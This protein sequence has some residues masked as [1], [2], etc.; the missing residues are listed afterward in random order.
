M[1]SF[2][3]RMATQKYITPQ[4]LIIMGT[5]GPNPISEFGLI[6]CKIIRK[7]NGSHHVSPLVESMAFGSY[8]N[9]F[10]DENDNRSW[11]T[12][13]VDI[14]RK[15]DADRFCT[16]KFT[17]SAMHDLIS[18]IN[19]CNSDAWF[20]DVASKMPILLVSGED[21]PVGNYGKSVI[22]VKK[23]LNKYNANVTMKLYKNNRH[24]VLND[25]A[26]EECVSDIIDFIKA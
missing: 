20:K 1:G 8:N 5:S 16:F 22:A 10:K 19:D 21:D 11:L 7:I 18:L 6:I 15:Y 9:R 23:N 17:I 13:N 25:N 26:H 2:V 24:E 3:V 12:T 4:K 14:R